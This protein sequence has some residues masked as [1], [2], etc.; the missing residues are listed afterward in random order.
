MSFILDA[1]RKSEHE[2]RTE[3]APDIMHAPLA[4]AHRH[5]P[6]WAI[7]LIGV[8]AA[9]LLGVTI[10]SFTE[11]A[12]ET[13]LPGRAS[14]QAPGYPLE[15]TT[16]PPGAAEPVRSDAASRIAA[17][18][19]EPDTNTPQ[20]PIPPGE[21]ESTASTAATASVAALTAP[22]SSA[23]GT[24]APS[25]PPPAPAQALDPG[26]LPSY[27]AAVA[28][29]IGINPLQLQLHVHSSV[30]ANR[31]VVINGSRRREGDRL[32]EGPLVESIVAEGVVLSY[33]GRRFLLTPN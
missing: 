5:L 30:A 28:E 25:P 15:P 29:G 14:L 33:Q 12:R 32:A 8:L 20:A 1:L 7:V 6:V 19:P 24:T 26:R 4:V 13:A 22:G 23:T 27:A 21:R 16:Q 10:Y 9:A 17:E 2:R 18:V 31:F 3:A 11:R